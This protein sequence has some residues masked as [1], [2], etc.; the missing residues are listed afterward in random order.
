MRSFIGGSFFMVLATVANRQTISYLGNVLATRANRCSHGFTLFPWERLLCTSTNQLFML[1]IFATLVSSVL[2]VQL[3]QCCVNCITFSF[4][5]C[6][7]LLLKLLELV[8]RL[9]SCHYVQ[10][11]IFQALSQSITEWVRVEARMSMHKETTACFS[12]TC[13][14]FHL[15]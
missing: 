15:F 1:L 7:V 5:F 8:C 4:N 2:Q 13:F 3:Q 11:T 6:G 10:I 14:T 12:H 9:F